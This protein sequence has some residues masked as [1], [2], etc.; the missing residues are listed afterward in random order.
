MTTISDA[1]QFLF[2]TYNRFPIT[3]VKGRGCSVWDEQGNEYLDFVAGIAVCNLGHCHP[4]IVEAVQKQ[5]NTLIH[6]SNLYHSKP[7]VDCARLLTEV[8]FADKVF[9]CNSGAEANEGAM[10]L[11]RKYMRD[12]CGNDRFEVITATNSFHGRTMMT[13]TATG[14]DKVKKGFEPLV[15]GFRHVPFN[16]MEALTEAITDRTAAVLLEP[17]QGE[18]GIV[19]PDLGYLSAVR[20]VCDE[21]GLLLIFDEIQTGMGRTGTLFAYQHYGVLP[22]IMTLAKGLAGGL[23]IG[24]VLTRNEIAASLGPGTHATTFGGNPVVTAA[25][26]AALTTINDP[27]FLGHCRAMGAALMEGLQQLKTTY[28]VIR[29][30]RGKGL[31]VGMDLSIPGAEVVRQC[32]EKGVLVNCVQDTVLRFIPPLVVTRREIDTLISTLDAVLAKI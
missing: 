10:K 14:Q 22:D 20:N 32:M 4:A 18:G 1:Q 19:C 29:E 11:T 25:A 2:N 21:R 17:I 9:F 12:R 5:V 7:Q 16:N 3:L 24:A 13:L 27:E 28:P 26:L 31:L 15:P 30:I 8:C 6:V 23:P